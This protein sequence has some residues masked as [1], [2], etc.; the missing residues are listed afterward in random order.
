M[1]FEKF[2][3]LMTLAGN[4]CL[5]KKDCY[6]VRSNLYIIILSHRKGSID[7]AALNLWFLLAKAM[8]TAEA[9][10]NIG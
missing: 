2:L 4:I 6:G 7:F 3:N 8:E 5:Y 1:G 9:P 10:D